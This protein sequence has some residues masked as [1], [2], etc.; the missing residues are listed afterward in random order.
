M[1]SLEFHVLPKCKHLSL[2][3]SGIYKS[4]TIFSFSPYLYLL[5][6]YVLLSSLIGE[7]AH[8]AMNTLF[9]LVPPFIHDALTFL[10]PI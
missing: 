10:P 4:S 5:I 9:L 1:N 2:H 6:F 8:W 3:C 7:T